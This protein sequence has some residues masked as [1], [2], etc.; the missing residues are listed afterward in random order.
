MRIGAGSYTYSW[1]AIQQQERGVSPEE[2]IFALV[3]KVWAT[4]LKIV[5][6]C[7]NVPLEKLNNNQLIE[8][9]RHC[10]DLGIDIQIGTRGIAHAHMASMLE[11]AKFCGAKLVRTMLVDLQGNHASVAEG[12][13]N[14]KAIMPQ[15]EMGGVVVGIENHDRHST[16]DLTRLLRAVDS[17]MLGVCIDT[18]NSFAAVETPDQVIRELMPFAKNLHL[19][20]FRV[21]RINRGMGFLIEGTPVGDGALNLELLK[22]APAGIDAIIEFWPPEQETI[23]KTVQ[24]EDA[25]VQRSLE[26]LGRMGWI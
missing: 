4:G 24:M 20:D 10:M 6:I 1:W 25:W 18:V 11:R 26:N 5:Q 3:D 9:G 14:L 19:K 17:P 7:D 13:E 23:D 21:R 15:Y 8:L 16:K 2:I 22:Q 12:I